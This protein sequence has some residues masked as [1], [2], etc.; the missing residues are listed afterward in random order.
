MG[1]DSIDPETCITDAVYIRRMP[2]CLLV[3]G[4]NAISGHIE[5]QKLRSSI[6]DGEILE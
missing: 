3:A 5:L 4:K 2:V 6:K 1:A